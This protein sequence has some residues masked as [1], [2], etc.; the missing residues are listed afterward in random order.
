M[1]QTAELILDSKCQLGE[2]RRVSRASAAIFSSISR[3]TLF[4][5]S[6]DG[7][8]ADQ[9]LFNLAVAAAA[10]ADDDTLVL[11]TSSIA[12]FQI[13][14]AELRSDRNRSRRKTRTNDSRVHPSGAFSW[15]STMDAT[16]EE[17]PIGA[18]CTIIALVR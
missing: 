9:W 15:I 13:P 16:E 5:V 7:E 14:M 1:N 12:G 4:A 17:G 6:A 8:I 11:A 3:E 10:V 2:V 18:R